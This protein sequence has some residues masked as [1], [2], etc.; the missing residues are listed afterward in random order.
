MYLLTSDENDQLVRYLNG[1]DDTFLDGEGPDKVFR[2]A[3][4]LAKKMRSDIR[5]VARER[6]GC[7]ERLERLQEKKKVGV[8]ER[9]RN[10]DF[11]Y[12]GLDSAD[13]GWAIVHTCRDMGLPCSNKRMDLLLYECYCSWFGSKLEVLTKEG[14][15]YTKF[16]PHFW[17]ATKSVDVT[18]PAP[19]AALE[20]VWEAGS[21]LRNFI[22]NVV[23]KYSTR[24][25]DALLRSYTDSY[26][27]RH[28][29]EVG[30]GKTNTPIDL[31][32]IFRWRNPQKP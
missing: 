32:D 28:A 16:G 8:E 15:A 23:R 7:K 20:R 5:A 26:P 27:Y 2:I 24:G 19:A 11:T 13:L 4:D 10:R 29:A 25:N 18:R 1:E 22:A 12:L 3:R 14:P 9:L 30:G 31:V 17:H 21:G 6:D